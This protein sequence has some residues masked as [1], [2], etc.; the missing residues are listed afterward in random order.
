MDMQPKVSIVGAG[1]AGFALAADL[2]SRGTNVLVY[3][4]PTHIRHAN[5]V[6]DKGCLRASGKIESSTNLRV[7][8]EMS[9]VV[10]FSKIIILTV[11]STGQQTVLRELKRFTLRQHTIIAIPGNLFSLIADA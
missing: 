11:P 7:T 5:Y 2:E 4:H 8:F 10:N 3:S 1:P 9:E 6:V